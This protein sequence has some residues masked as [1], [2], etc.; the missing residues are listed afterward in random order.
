MAHIVGTVGAAGAVAG[1]VK[2]V[3]SLFG[4]QKDFDR[5][6]AQMQRQHQEAM[7]NLRQE[8]LEQIQQAKETAVKEYQKHLIERREKYPRPPYLPDDGVPTIGIMGESGTGKSTFLNTILGERVAASGVGECT[9]DPGIYQWGDVRLVDLPGGCT[10]NFKAEHYF[11]R[12]GIRYFDTV[13]CLSTDARAKELGMDAVK[14]LTRNDVPTIFVLS[15]VDSVLRGEA[16]SKGRSQEEV[17]EEMQTKFNATFSKYN[18]PVYF[19]SAIEVQEECGSV[20]AA[21]SRRMPLTRLA[22]RDWLPLLQVMRREAILRR[23]L[24]SGQF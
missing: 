5:R 1:F 6:M 10:T 19:V 23:N 21:G 14:H 4:K 3:F 22:N 8:T 15:K 24:I 13:V 9:A 7:A 12:F 20:Q 16:I 18:C 11:Q 2:E 17:F